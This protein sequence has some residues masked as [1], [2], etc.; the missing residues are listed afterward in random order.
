MLGLPGSRSMHLLH[1][2]VDLGHL[3]FKIEDSFFLLFEAGD[4]VHPHWALDEV[5][6]H[7]AHHLTLYTTTD[8]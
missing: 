2:C 6:A 8:R 4:R 3:S 7:Q 5:L 1:R